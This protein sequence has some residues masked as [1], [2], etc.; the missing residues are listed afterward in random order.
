MWRTIFY[1]W[2][3]S[4]WKGAE[5]RLFRFPGLS[6]RPLYLYVSRV[7]ADWL[8]ISRT[9]D[10]SMSTG[11]HFSRDPSKNTENVRK[12]GVDFTEASSV[13]YDELARLIDDPDHSEN[14]DRFVIM[15]LSSK[16]RLLLICHCYRSNDSEIRIISARKAL[17][18]ETKQYKGWLMRKEYDFS[19]SRPNPYAKRLKKPITIRLDPDALEYFKK[20]AESVEMPYQTLINLYLKDCANKRRKPEMSWT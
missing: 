7:T 14:E 13:F 5:W 4:R 17:K 1:R 15:G 16:F 18:H 10:V 6:V 11:L 8:G 9:Y 12:H 3:T 20:T 2:L 19:N